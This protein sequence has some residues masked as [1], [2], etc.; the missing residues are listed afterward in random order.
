MK[1]RAR[2]KSRVFGDKI[3]KLQGEN[4]STGKGCSPKLA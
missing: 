4:F 3:L 1:K 2:K